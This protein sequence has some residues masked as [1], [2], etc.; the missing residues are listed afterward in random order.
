MSK[1]WFVFSYVLVVLFKGN[2]KLKT[3]KLVHINS[4]NQDQIVKNGKDQR[5]YP[6]KKKFKKSELLLG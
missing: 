1:A 4:S 6:M 2:S 5:L 3:S